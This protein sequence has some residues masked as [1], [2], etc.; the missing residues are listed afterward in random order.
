[1]EEM[2]HSAAKVS[3]VFLILLDFTRSIHCA[4]R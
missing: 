2:Y 4:C 3:I 1:M